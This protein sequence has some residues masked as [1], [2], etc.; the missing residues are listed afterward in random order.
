MAGYDGMV[1]RFEGPDQMRAAWDKDQSYEFMW[2]PSDVLSTQRS[3][4][5]THVIRWNYGDMLGAFA[6]GEEYGFRCPELSFAFDTK[7]LH[8]KADVERYA[9]A[10]V[11]W[12]KGRGS[13]YRGN[14][15]LAVWGSDFQFVNDS[16]VSL[17]TCVSIEGFYSPARHLHTL[18]VANRAVQCPAMYAPQ[19]L[20]FHSDCDAALAPP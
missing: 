12:S 10:L 15:H 20:R 3:S 6:S 16:L 1:I 18:T 17:S 13:V 2:E 19:N 9:A 5:A 14:R 7:V 4:I 11:A 8:T